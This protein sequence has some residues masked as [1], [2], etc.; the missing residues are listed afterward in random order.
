MVDRDGT[1]V[2]LKVRAR[3][4][5]AHGGAA[6]CVTARKQ[7]YLLRH[8]STPPCRFDVVALDGGALTWLYAAFDAG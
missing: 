1:L 3:A 5:A 4:D 7:H 2:F 6:A 8:A